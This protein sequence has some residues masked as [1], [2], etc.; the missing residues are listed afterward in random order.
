MR[1][2]EQQ[3]I[4]AARLEAFEIMRDR[5]LG[6]FV[7]GP[8]FLYQRYQQRTRARVN[9]RVP[10]QILDR[11]SVSARRD[12]RLGAYDADFATARSLHR[13]SRARLDYAVHLYHRE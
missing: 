13:R 5:A 6:N 7:V 3:R 10:I 1:A 4:D 9:L 2:A 11:P 8:A 12:R